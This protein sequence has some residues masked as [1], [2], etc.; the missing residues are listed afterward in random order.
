[1][2][3]AANFAFANR[4]IM[5]HKVR[6]IFKEHFNV[7]VNL[8]YDITHNIAKLEEHIINGKS[9][10]LIVHRKGATRAFKNQ[11][12]L[13]PGD[14]GTSSYILIG[15]EKSESLAFGSSAHG[16]GRVLGRRQAKKRLN[17]KD[18]LA[19]LKSKNISIIAK[20]KGTIVEEAPAFIRI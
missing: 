7:D 4:Q 13:I 19:E 5:G 3:G 11:P 17:S 12:V 20:S 15:T 2:N 10:K 16:A 14:M 18:I 9:K 6:K 1:M 8:L